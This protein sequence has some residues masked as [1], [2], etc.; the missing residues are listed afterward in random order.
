MR[1]RGT[2]DLSK[3]LKINGQSNHLYTRISKQSRDIS[4]NKQIDTF[5]KF[6]HQEND[7]NY[8]KSTEAEDNDSHDVNIN[9]IRGDLALHRVW[10]GVVQ[11]E[12]IE[13]DGITEE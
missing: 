10:L 6:D 1:M 11:A 7:G 9:E 5:N 3:I 13:H 2:V 4:T 8:N 12:T